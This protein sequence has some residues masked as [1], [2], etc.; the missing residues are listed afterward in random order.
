MHLVLSW[1]HL[2]VNPVFPFMCTSHL[3][4][5]C[6]P[7]LISVF[8]DPYIR[9]SFT[10]VF[11]VSNID[12][13]NLVY[14]TTQLPVWLVSSTLNSESV[15]PLLLRLHSNLQTPNSKLH[16]SQTKS[17]NLSSRT[18]FEILRHMIVG[19][20]S[21]QAEANIQTPLNSKLQSSGAV[22]TR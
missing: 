17:L 9:L 6:Y 7:Q 1:L 11:N 10:Y 5:L 19:W 14:S 3:S 18:L 13:H 2:C 21:T 22:H 15:S 12:L 16:S 20:C 8:S 4:H